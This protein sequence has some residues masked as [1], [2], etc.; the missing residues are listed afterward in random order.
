LQA[1]LERLVVQRV[2]AV[3]HL[4]V[5]L[6][7]EDRVHVRVLRLGEVKL[8]V[9]A[10]VARLALQREQPELLLLGLGQRGLLRVELGGLDV[11]AL[12]FDV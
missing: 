7:V 1:H 3:R 12:L 9:L 5:Q 2:V 4:P 6:L 8:E 11:E 10:D